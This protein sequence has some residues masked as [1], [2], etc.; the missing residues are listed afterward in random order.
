MKKHIIHAALQLAGA[1]PV[2]TTFTFTPAASYQLQ[3]HVTAPAP[4][5]KFEKAFDMNVCYYENSVIFQQNIQLT[6][7]KATVTGTVEY[8]VCSNLQCLPPATT[9]FNIPIH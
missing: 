9:A 8:M 6:G 5:T 7:G 4:L 1:G 3:G 2:K